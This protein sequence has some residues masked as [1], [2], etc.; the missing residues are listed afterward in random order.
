MSAKET[1]QPAVEEEE[2]EEIIEGEGEQEDQ[3]N[4]QE[5]GE[6][7]DENK[8]EGEGDNEGEGQD[9]A[10]GEGDDPDS[11]SVYVKNVDY[12]ADPNSIKEHFQD[13]G[14]I[15][16]VTII[17][18]KIT[19]HPLGYAYIE[20]ED[21]E[22]VEKA[23]ELMNDSLFKGRQITVMKKRKNVPGRG[24]ASFRSRFPGFRGPPFYG[25]R[26]FYRYRPY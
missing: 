15:N 3:N 7:Q 1:T 17:C 19:G 21:K 12:S 23:I 13:C 18:N 26:P 4:A 11:R 9:E 2:V 8:Q 14:S 20:F 25:R 16:R 24:R 5:E 22:G 6:G 10:E